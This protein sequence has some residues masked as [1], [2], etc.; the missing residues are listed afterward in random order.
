MKKNI[1][2]SLLEERIGLDAGAIG[3]KV[4]EKAF[5][6]RMDRCGAASLESYAGILADSSDEWNR[7]IEMVVV[8]ETWFF[9]NRK[10][11]DYLARFVKNSWLPENS[12]QTLRILSIPCSTGEEPYTIAMTLMDAGLPKDRFKIVGMDISENALKKARDGFYGQGSFRGKDLDFR[13]RYFRSKDHGYQLSSRVSDL[14]RFKSGNVLDA[15]LMAGAPYDVVFCRNLMIYMSPEA[16]DQTLAAMSRLLKEKGVFFCGHAE[17]QT[18]IDWGFEAINET[19]VFACRKRCRESRRKDPSG[20]AAKTAVK[21][22]AEEKRQSVT[23][24]PRVPDP[25]PSLKR[26]ASP[27][28]LQPEVAERGAGKTADLFLKARA[29]ADQGQLSEALELCRTF[30]DENPVHGDAHFLMGLIHEALDNV[31]MAEAFFNRAIYLNPEHAEALNHMAFIELQR[32]NN[33]GA[34]RLRQRAR[35]IGGGKT[36]PD[37][38]L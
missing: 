27:E 26:A 4:I 5:K 28:P 15:H 2:E 10:V 18:A 3:R 21:T 24:K 34:Q 22:T 32:G 25:I 11:F 14:V 35:R 30:L 16:R 19:G 20:A 37:F 31:E 33:D 12:A 29:M 8:P 6:R 17:R 38:K 36:T 1:I 7:L 23:Q 13:D 9:R